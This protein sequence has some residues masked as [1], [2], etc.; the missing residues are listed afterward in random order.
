LRLSGKDISQVEEILHP[1]RVKID[2]ERAWQAMQRDKKN[3]GGELRLVLLGEDGPEWDVA[4]PAA[5]VR[6]EL[7]ALIA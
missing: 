5:D 3:V 4:V 2:R 6:R 1:K 7:D